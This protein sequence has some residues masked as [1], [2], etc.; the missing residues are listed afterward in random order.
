MRTTEDFREP[1][2]LDKREMLMGLPP[3]WADDSLREQI[4][5][6][7]AE[8]NRC[9]VALDDDPTGTQTV[10]D[11]SVLTR[12]RVEDIQ[13]TLEKG[14]P[15]LYILTNSRSL[16]LNEAQRINAEIAQNLSAAS[17]AV[18]RSITLV[19]RSDS[20]LRGHY[21]GEVDALREA[22]QSAQG[23][24]IDGVCIIPF[25][26]EGGRY[27][28][29]NIHWVQEG[30]QLIPAAQTP[31]AQDSV[32][33]Y[34]H[35]DLP[36]W[37]EEKT[38]G[39]VPA[40]KVMAISLDEI[41]EDGPEWVAARLQKAEAGCVVV[42]N[43]ADYRDLDV[44]VLALQ[45][46]EVHG[47]RFLFRTAASFVKVAAGL[48]DRPLLTKEEIIDDRR[49]GG[50]LIVFGS[51]LPKSTAQLEAVRAIEGVQALELPVL[52]ILDASE[53][54]STL[55][56]AS[57][58]LNTALHAGADALVYTSRE[59]VRGKNHAEDLSIAQRISTALIELVRRVNLE[60]RYVIGKGG[61]TSSDLATEGMYMTAARVLGQVLPGVPVWRLGPQSRWPGLPYVVFPG[62][63]GELSSVA[64]VVQM[65]RG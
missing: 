12:W 11:V 6:R 4:A 16:S 58:M 1:E 28:I 52:Q 23:T 17:H 32:F 34:R 45:Q 3:I 49:S 42:V 26:P 44:F 20:T 27:T 25:F 51:Y 60:P 39:S 10:Y 54:A 65:L 8:S 21:P 31:Y 14:E 22:W 7:N 64:D 53:R 18:G 5:R 47:R 33:G 2:P 9:V 59:Q 30:A 24:S 13:T 29:R 50:G 41:R 37:V 15:A 48:Q 62:N 61:I 40:S 36:S 55:S 56:K 46:V 63:V 19:S 35:S 43:A 38:G 57:T